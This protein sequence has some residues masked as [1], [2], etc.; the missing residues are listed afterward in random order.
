MS[1]NRKGEIL[2]I[3]SGK[4]TT[5][6]DVANAVGGKIT[7][8]PRKI[9]GRGSFG[10]YGKNWKIL[11]WKYK[12]DFEWVKFFSNYLKA[13]DDNKKNCRMCASKDLKDILHLGQH[14]LVNS[15]LK[16]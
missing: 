13:N 3:G 12:T 9:R 1:E 10:K 4:A 14:S 2:N 7:F 6:E 8:I 16:K 15:Y 11:D 5:V